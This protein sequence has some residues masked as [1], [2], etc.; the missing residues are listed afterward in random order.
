MLDVGLQHTVDGIAVDIGV[1]LE[2]V[3]HVD[4]F[5]DEDLVLDFD[6]ALGDSDESVTG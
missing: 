6:F 4:A 5:Q 3:G 1:D 2:L